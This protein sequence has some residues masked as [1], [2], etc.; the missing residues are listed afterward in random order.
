MLLWGIVIF[1]V[2]A[3]AW[4]GVF[5]LLGRNTQALGLKTSSELFVFSVQ[6]PKKELKAGEKKELQEFIA[7]MDIFFQNLYGLKESLQGGFLGFEIAS[8]DGL[9]NFYFVV[10]KSLGGAIEKQITAQYPEAWIEPVGEYNPFP[11][12]G[13]VAVAQLALRRSFVFPIDTY[14][15]LETDG[16]NAL[17]NA[18]SKLEEG[19]EA[20]LIQILIKP[21]DETW[22]KKARAVAREMQQGIKKEGFAAGLQK[23][24]LRK[25]IGPGGE[26]KE[27]PK[28][29]TKLTQGQEELIRAMEE[30][31][32]HPGFETQIR[33]LSVSQNQALA[34]G[35][36][37]GVLAAFNQ[38]TFDL[39]NGFGVLKERGQELAKNVL[40][41]LWGKPEKKVI[42]SS[43]E[44]ATVFHLPT[45][46]T[47]TPNINWLKARRLPPPVNLPSNGLLVGKNVFRGQE[48]LVRIKEDDRRRHFYVIGRTGTGKTTWMQNMVLQDIREGRGV[49]VIDPHGDMINWLLERMPR[50]RAEEVIHFYPPDIER[51]LGLNMLE[52]KNATER[53]LVSSEMI[54]IFQKLFDPTGSLGITGPVFERSMRNSMLALMADPAS[55]ATLIEIP[56][57]FVDEEFRR[58]KLQHVSDENVRAFWEKELAAVLK[59]SQAGEHMT[60]VLSKL[61]R[62]VSNELMRNII[63]QG[64]SAINFREVMDKGQI[65]LINLAKGL[66]GEVNSNL[67]GF[68]IVT[69]LQMAALSRADQP[70]EKRRDFYL[71]IDEFQ[72]VTTDSVATIL[73]EA[74]KYRLNLTIA[75][76]FIAQLEEKIRDAVLGNVGT[77]MAF[78]IG[79]QD[80]EMIGK[81]FEPEVSQL[82]LVNIE[83]RNAYLKLM[84]D[85]ATSRPFTIT[86]LPPMGEGNPKLAQAI[87]EL[88]RVKYGKDKRLVEAE[89]KGRLAAIRNFQL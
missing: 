47:E 30:K 38:F 53:D 56:R 1:I 18:L 68:I 86:T 28:E 57:L 80:A 63:G 60:Y 26:N 46:L 15:K 3:A 5:W 72:N 71:Y 73:S 76:Q 2:L 78:R 34:Q 82:D 33:V 17:T 32:N 39:G 31:A 16:L 65:L 67:L 14:K 8:F 54:A 88:S 45:P 52:A 25:L 66:V 62:F 22:Q 44:L 59:G 64:K 70:E 85:G 87:K 50:E 79:P 13:K 11:K 7:P 41:R 55:S 35:L 24:L 69:K 12:R 58:Q 21:V 51:P 89:L 49:C 81:E 36:L 77:M 9:V 37:S 6:L 23:E 61:D 4:G 29:P 74:R 84:I 43:E 83:N 40:F 48:A 27:S 10:P 75:H 20:A 19:K 42:L